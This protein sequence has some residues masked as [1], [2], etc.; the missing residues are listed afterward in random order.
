MSPSTEVQLCLKQ[1]AA[2]V[3]DVDDITSQQEQGSSLSP[4]IRIVRPT[5]TLAAFE[6]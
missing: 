4:V 6:R 3:L 1:L 2:L 5:G